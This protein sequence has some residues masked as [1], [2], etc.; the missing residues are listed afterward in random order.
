MP[1]G[2]VERY[3]RWNLRALSSCDTQ[4]NSK[5]DLKMPLLPCAEALPHSFPPV[6]R[7]PKSHVST[8]DLCSDSSVG[9]FHGEL[10]LKTLMIK[11]R[12]VCGSAL[13]CVEIANGGSLFCAFV[14]DDEYSDVQASLTWASLGFGFKQLNDE[15]QPQTFVVF[16]GPNSQKVKRRPL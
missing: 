3:R 1:P 8:V 15:Y 11:L 5:V 7:S 6:I 14:Q 13:I 9:V 12:R 16:D 10:E 2:V 4:Y